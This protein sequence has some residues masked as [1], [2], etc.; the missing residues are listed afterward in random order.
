MTGE[1]LKKLRKSLGMTQKELAAKIGIVPNSVARL[2]RNE[3]KIS[4]VLERFLKFLKKD[5]TRDSHSDSLR[6]LSLDWI[7]TGKDRCPKHRTNSHH[8]AE[9]TK[10]LL[11]ICVRK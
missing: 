6:D 3:R 11:T 1:E 10:R 7:Q 9:S 2:E 5:L 4:I 8:V